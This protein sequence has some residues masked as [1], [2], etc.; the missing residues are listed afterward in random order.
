[1]FNST[2]GAYALKRC[3]YATDSGY[4][5]KLIKLINDYGLDKLDIQ[6]L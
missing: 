6:K 2:W 3:G 5:G 1:M 4:P